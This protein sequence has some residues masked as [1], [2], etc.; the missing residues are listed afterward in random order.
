MSKK[1]VATLQKKNATKARQNLRLKLRLN[2][3][4]DLIA[5]L[6]QHVPAPVLKDLL[7]GKDPP[8]DERRQL[9]QELTDGEGRLK[10]YPPFLKQFACDLHYMSA[11]CDH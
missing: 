2:K 7:A 5:R 9:M 8:V 11:R 4:Q 10:G 3:A 6:K 1:K